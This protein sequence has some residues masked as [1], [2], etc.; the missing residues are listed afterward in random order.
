MFAAPWK[1]YTNDIGHRSL[2][3]KLTAW[4]LE[5]LKGSMQKAISAT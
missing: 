4:I 1:M 3:Q 2:C 5:T